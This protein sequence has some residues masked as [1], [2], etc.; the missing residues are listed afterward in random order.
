M[1]KT[2]RLK[3]PN[4]EK[5][6]SPPTSKTPIPSKTLITS[7]Q[8]KK[9]QFDKQ[10]SVKKPLNNTHAK[11]KKR[12]NTSK[13]KTSAQRFSLAISSASNLPIICAVLGF[14]MVCFNMHLEQ[15]I[16]RKATGID[17]DLKPRYSLANPDP[18]FEAEKYDQLTNTFRRSIFTGDLMADNLG[19]TTTTPL[20]VKSTTSLT[21]KT[22]PN[23]ASLLGNA[24]QSGSL[25]NTAQHITQIP[26]Y[27]LSNS[28]SNTVHL[29]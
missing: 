10:I 17:D 16:W 14:I 3:K 28:F 1:V 25:Y 11:T 19:N 12:K 26:V 15:R 20:F 22:T 9:L 29:F 4:E 21:R 13:P 18:K 23:P 5:L 2:T 8:P 27:F 24:K 7:K 6:S